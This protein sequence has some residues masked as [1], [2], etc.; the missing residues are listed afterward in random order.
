M[1]VERAD[2]GSYLEELIGEEPA[3]LPF[4]EWVNALGAAGMNPFLVEFLR[5]VKDESAPL[6][7]KLRSY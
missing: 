6:L 2:L 3:I 5:R 7:P 1:V 4:I